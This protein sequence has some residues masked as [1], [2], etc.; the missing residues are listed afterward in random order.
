[1][2]ATVLD[3]DFYVSTLEQL[4][5]IF[6]DLVSGPPPD[7]LTCTSNCDEVGRPHVGR[8]VPI[9]DGPKTERDKRHRNYRAGMAASQARPPPEVPA[10]S[11]TMAMI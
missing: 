6:A 9:A 4:P 2:A 1:V 3:P 5:G 11:A 8:L 10:P 7:D